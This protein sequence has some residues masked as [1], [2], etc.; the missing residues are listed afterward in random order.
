MPNE[1]DKSRSSK[2]GEGKFSQ[3]SIVGKSD[4]QARKIGTR[5]TLHN[6]FALSHV[7]HDSSNADSSDHKS[8]I[9]GYAG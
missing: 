8:L 3:P 6:R 7:V 2:R 5:K 1:I 4:E 9:I